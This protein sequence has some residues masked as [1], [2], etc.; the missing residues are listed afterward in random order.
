M[1]LTRR[2]VSR[3][4][5][6]AFF[7]AAIVLGDSGRS[8]SPRPAMPCATAPS[9]G[10]V[11]DAATAIAIGQAVLVRVYGEKQMAAEQ[12]LTAVLEYDMWTVVGTLHC[13]TAMCFGGTAG[14]NISKTDGRITCVWH[15]R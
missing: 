6:S 4:A 13:P 1:S 8:Q 2:F 11:P 15:G 3:S 9:K 5:L 12:P 7:A 10:Y 14:V